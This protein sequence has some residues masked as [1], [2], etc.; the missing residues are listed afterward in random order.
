MRWMKSAQY[1]MRKSF[2]FGKIRY[3]N[4]FRRVNPVVVDVRLEKKGG[5]EIFKT[6]C[7]TGEKT[8]T[9]RTPEF[10][11]FAACG[12]IWNAGQTDIVCGGQCLDTIAKYESQLNNPELFSVLY[13]LWKKYHLNS[14]YIGTPEQEAA[15]KEWIELGGHE[16][17]YSKVC[18]ML[19]KRD[20][21]E[22][23]YTGLTVE[24]RYE[25]E[26]YKYGHGWVVQELPEDVIAQIRH[27][28]SE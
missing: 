7:R 24:K 21:Y 20:L 9:G 14:M 16:Y 12:Q 6:D 25:N 26:P 18:D 15:V 4:K 13:D 10:W 1:T 19:E 17:D 22:V 3:T 11:E 8:V 23:N 28:L 27:L 2:D 5:R